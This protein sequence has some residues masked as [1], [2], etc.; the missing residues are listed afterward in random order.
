M[1]ERFCGYPGAAHLPQMRSVLDHV[2]ISSDLV[3]MQRRAND[4]AQIK[5][6]RLAADIARALVTKCP[7]THNVY[8]RLLEEAAHITT[9]P[10]ALVMDFQLAI[11]MTARP[12]FVEG[13]CAVLIDK[14]ND[15]GWQPAWLEDVSSAVVDDVFATAGLPALR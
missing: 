11:K 2:F 5:E 4:L 9:L 3:A 8:V 7:M 12:D 1:I 14:T 13:V 6:N 15:A 10:E